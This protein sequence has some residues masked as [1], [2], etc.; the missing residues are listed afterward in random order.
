MP[1]IPLQ[2][3]FI[4]ISKLLSGCPELCHGIS[5]KRGGSGESQFG[6]NIS[7]RVGDNE[8]IVRFNWKLF[9]D[10]L[11][12]SEQQI[13]FQRQIHSAIVIEVV[14][15]GIYD[16]CDAL[17]TNIPNL[18]LTVTIAD[19]IPVLIYDPVKR[20]VSIVH[21]GWKGTHREIV[22]KALRKMMESYN[23]VP[24]DIL[25]FIGPGAGPCCYNVGEEVGYL[26]PSEYLAR[27][28]DKLF[29]DLKQR[30]QNSVL[31]EGVLNTSIEVSPLC[32]ICGKTLFH[33][34]RRD[35]VQ[36]GRMLGIIGFKDRA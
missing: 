20:C 18:Y 29:L 6:F 10:E 1:V 36:S 14:N 31:A 32:T 19:C 16:N 2:R 34:Y 7:Y 35:G 17:I 15:P 21:S 11:Q 22:R 23:S 9:C 5:T 26:F 28:D 13:A 8:E 25:C 30:I 4:I 33:S 27:R 12:I 24:S 3:P